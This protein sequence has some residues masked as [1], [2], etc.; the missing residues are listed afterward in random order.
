[1]PDSL[2]DSLPEPAFLVADD[3]PLFRAAIIHVLRERLPQYAIL[4][5]ASAPTLGAAL[6]WA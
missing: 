3:H 1:M 2:S 5:A 4:E 6:R